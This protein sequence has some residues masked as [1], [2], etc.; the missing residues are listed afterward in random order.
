MHIFSSFILKIF[1]DT[2][3]YLQNLLRRKH[4]S[5]QALQGDRVELTCNQEALEIVRTEAPTSIIKWALNDVD[6]SPDGIRVIMK[7]NSNIG[8]V[9]LLFIVY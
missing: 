9:Y 7:N 6:V 2:K 5:L 1:S 4:Q 8:N 3:K